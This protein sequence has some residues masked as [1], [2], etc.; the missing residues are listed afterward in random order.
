MVSA[1]SAVCLHQTRCGSVAARSAAWQG[2]SLPK[3]L[4]ARPCAQDRTGL[5][6]H[7]AIII[8]LEFGGQFD[9]NSLCISN[10]QKQVV[11]CAMPS[12][13]PQYRSLVAAQVVSPCQQLWAIIDTI[14]HV[15][16]IQLALDKHQRMMISIAAQPDT[17]TQQPI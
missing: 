11:A 6:W 1:S 7:F 5:R 14:A 13:S 9:V 4:L 8:L 2:V 15:V 17:L 3:R 12:R 16:D 10:A